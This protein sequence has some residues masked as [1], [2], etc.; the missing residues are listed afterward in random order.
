MRV[1][2]V[3]DVFAN[4]LLVETL[5]SEHAH[6]ITCADSGE[7]AL[8][9]F[10]SKEFDVVL[11]DVNLPDIS[12]RDVARKVRSTF[13]SEG[14]PCP[15]LIAFTGTVEFDSDLQQVFEAVLTKPFRIEDL[16]ALIDGRNTQPTEPEATTD[17]PAELETYDP[18]PALSVFSKPDRASQFVGWF[19]E[20]TEKLLSDLRSAI[21]ASNRKAA[22]GAAHALKGLGASAK[23][24][25]ATAIARQLEVCLD[26]E[27]DNPEDC[28]KTDRLLREVIRQFEFVGSRLRAAVDPDVRSAGDRTG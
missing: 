26:T 19:I 1:L 14:R 13:E 4:R 17:G 10:E 5:L 2:V 6:E 25:S 21:A 16:F 12:G 11:L 20:D 24:E 22:K 3:D 15:R 27:G 28:D 18:H 7:A 8:A 9:E 23:A